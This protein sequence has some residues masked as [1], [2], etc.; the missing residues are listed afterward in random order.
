MGRNDLYLL[1]Y[2]TFQTLQCGLQSSFVHDDFPFLELTQ[3]KKKK[4]KFNFVIFTPQ[5]KIP[6]FPSL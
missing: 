6:G 3:K 5:S 2:R 4:T 1:D